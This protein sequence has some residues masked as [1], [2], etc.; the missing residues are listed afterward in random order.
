MSS[1]AQAQAPQGRKI[2]VLG[3]ALSR[4]D[5]PFND[6]SWEIW[7]VN[8]AYAYVPRVTRTFEL[9]HLQNMGNRRN[10]QYEEWLKKGKVPT[11]MW[12]TNPDWPAVVAYPREDIMGLFGTYWTNSISWMLA[13]AIAELSDVYTMPDGRAIRL[14]KPG[15]ELSMFGVDM[16]ADSEYADQ[17]RNV[18]YYVG[19]ARGMGIPVFI[20]DTSDICKAG[21]VY[22]IDTNAP[23]R[24][25][26]QAHLQAL[27]QEKAQLAQNINQM[28]AQ[29][30]EQLAAFWRNDGAQTT[31]R[32]IIRV[33]T[34]GTE[35]PIGA[36]VEAKDRGAP[37]L[38][39][40]LAESTPTPEGNGHS[41]KIPESVKG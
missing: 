12:Q 1:E 5:A 39:A 4:K 25:K 30:Q 8:D 22:G 27:K 33:W 15:A 41:E 28:D 32:D 35:I 17:R 16:A 36:I 24:I 29:K 2:V 10:P 37:M 19:I 11:Y 31:V 14:A 23:L 6:D 26:L 9:H 18:E 38:G 3:F 20:P 7:A 34:S 40:P 21:S 13:L